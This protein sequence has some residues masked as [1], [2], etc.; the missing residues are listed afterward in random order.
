MITCIYSLESKHDTYYDKWYTYYI[1]SYVLV[2]TY[3]ISYDDIE[4]S[5]SKL[6]LK[7]YLMLMMLFAHQT[8]V[9]LYFGFGEPP[10]RA[11]TMLHTTTAMSNWIVK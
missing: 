9:M 8:W 6:F 10:N 11:V 1:L 3:D 7:K 2:H 4:K 5:I